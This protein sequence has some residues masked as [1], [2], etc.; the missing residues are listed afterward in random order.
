M[1][2]LK[3]KNIT[4]LVDASHPYAVEI[5]KNAIEACNRLNIDYIRYERP[6]CVEE[7]KN[8]IKVVK[9][10]DYGELKLKLENI[11]GTILNTTGSRNLDEI[12]S[13]GL[14]NR[15]I[16]R[17]LPTVKVLSEFHDRH[18][19]VDDI[20]ALKGP[21]GYE[22]N[23]AFIREYRARAMLLKDSGREGGTFE[24]IRAC[25]DCGIYAFVME[26]KK[27]NY[28]H[29]VFHNVGDLVEYIKSCTMKN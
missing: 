6:S 11:D 3:E 4:L 25:L 14:K 26:R 27:I 29:R 28:H 19:P 17:V 21:V 12:L 24:K 2:K 20:I 8:E 10:K 7:F 22:L 9:V 18:I 15:I 23:C 5:S 13:L 16:Y 1:E